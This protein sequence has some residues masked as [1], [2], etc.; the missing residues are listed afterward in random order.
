MPHSSRRI[1]RRRNVRHPVSWVVDVRK[2]EHFLYASIANV[3]ELGLFVATPT[4]M[5]EGTELELRFQPPGHEAFHVRAVVRWVNT[6][7]SGVPNP[8][9]GVALLG[10]DAPMRDRLKALIRAI[11]Y[12]EDDDIA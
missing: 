2:G 5:P 12:V 6:V 4:P 10:I 8:G 1:S 3:S 9:V 11:A 7:S